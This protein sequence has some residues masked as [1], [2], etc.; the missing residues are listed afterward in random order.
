MSATGYMALSHTYLAIQQVLT[1][2][3]GHMGQHVRPVGLMA[4]VLSIAACLGE[5]TSTL[6]QAALLGTAIC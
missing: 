5:S 2:L 4:N 6:Q 3:A 1:L